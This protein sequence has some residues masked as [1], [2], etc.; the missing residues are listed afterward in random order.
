MTTSPTEKQLDLLEEAA[1]T[2]VGTPF[3]AN[4]AVKGAGVCCHRLVAEIYF[5]AG[6]LPRFELPEGPPMHGCAGANS[7]M[8]D[9]LDASAFFAD[10]DP[11]RICRRFGA[12]A[13]LIGLVGPGDLL[14]SAPARV[15]HH[16]ALA[17][18]G[19]RF[20]H[21]V[22]GGKTDI[23]SGFPAPWAKRLARIYRPNLDRHG[24]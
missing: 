19:D 22:W 6:W 3:V 14:L 9:F 16:L 2:W 10:N 24:L 7:R 21:V 12:H 18:R 4:S 15:P 17:L 20:I 13:A 5:E 1:A 8:E 23:V 11:T